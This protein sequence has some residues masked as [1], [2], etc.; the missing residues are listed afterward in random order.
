MADYISALTGPQMDVALM[1]MA[2]H[3][4]EAWA[5]G[6]RAGTPVTSGD[7]TFN[8][9]SK[10]YAS[11]AQSYNAAAQAAAARAESAIPASTEGAVFFSFAQTLTDAEKAQAQTNIGAGGV[12]NP[13]LL[14]N[15]Y[16]VGG[17]VI[18]QR[19][20][21]SW[22]SGGY[23]IDMWYKSNT[24]GT[25]SST[26]NGLQVVSDDSN[27]TNMNQYLPDTAFRRLLNKTITL[28]VQ[29]QSGT[30]ESYTFTMPSTFP[31]ET[32]NLGG[33]NLT[34]C[35]VDLIWRDAGYMDFR[36]RTLANVTVT[37]RAAKLEVGPVSTLGN[38]TRIDRSEEWRK[39]V[40]YFRRITRSSSGTSLCR[41][42]TAQSTTLATIPNI[43]DSL[44]M[45]KT[46]TAS[47]T[48]EVRFWYGDGTTAAVTAVS[49]IT[50]A[51]GDYHLQV[52]ASGLTRGT[53]GMLQLVTGAYIDLDAQP[54]SS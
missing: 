38:E 52:T 5:V 11:R 13:N 26:S 41:L 21:S 8:N 30:V 23:M 3:D 46:P 49:A 15:P 39:C 19:G 37:Y 48:G 24:Y 2:M 40:Y 33:G 17:I 50:N 4:S 25:I 6:E 54:I 1:D 20:G 45:S 53:V 42:G 51:V 28:S 36:I 9:N 29:Y 16:F 31:T 22:S 47:M 10:Y 12:C 27:T 14:I 44:P 18:N 34:N 43:T 32:T 7:E 35:I